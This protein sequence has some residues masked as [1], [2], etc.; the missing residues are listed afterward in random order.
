MQKRYS[1]YENTLLL[2]AKLK[3]GREEI[4]AAV[5]RR[6]QNGEQTHKQHYRGM[7]GQLLVRLTKIEQIWGT[8][9]PI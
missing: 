9:S 5:L 3:R 4:Q 1:T 8:Y 6:I 7:S 2:T